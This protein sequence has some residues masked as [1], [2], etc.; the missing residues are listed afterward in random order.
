VSTLADLQRIPGLIPAADLS[1]DLDSARRRQ[2]RLCEAVISPSSP[3]VGQG[4]REG[5]FRTHYDAAV[6]AIHRNGK[7][8]GQKIGD[9]RLE[10]GDTLL[11]QAGS[12][13]VRAHRNNPDF[14]LVSEIGEASP[15]RHER[16]WV[17][18][19]I[20]A[21]LVVVLTLP[22]VLRWLPV[23]RSLPEWFEENR[24]IF[25]LLAAGSMVVTRALSAATARRSVD[26]QVLVIIAAAL[27]VGAAMEKSGAA[28]ALAHFTIDLVPASWG[29]VGVL[30]AVW[31]LTW[32]LTELMSNNAAA[33]LMFP[34]AMSAAQQAGADP[35]AFAVTIAIAA[36]TSFILPVGY[37]TH[38]MVFGPG[39]YRVRDFVRLGVPM[40]LIWFGI[41]MALIP[42]LWL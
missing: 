39:G 28:S 9:V 32:L 6:V 10:A 27:G 1:Y 13:F 20:A 14:F 21:G 40:T 5:N 12:G 38:L 41:A 7:R 11:L 15:V 26:W 42:S 17:A 25:A 22:E 23:P 24:V 33:A 18:A 36:S 2:R 31:L 29:T 19:A 34:V 8:L 16:A 4:I 35:R 37:Q 30:G 3:L